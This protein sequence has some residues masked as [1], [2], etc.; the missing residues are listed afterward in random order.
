MLLKDDTVKRRASRSRLLP[1]WIASDNAASYT[2]FVV[3]LTEFFN[4]TTD[5]YLTS[6][7]LIYWPCKKYLIITQTSIWSKKHAYF[8]TNTIKRLL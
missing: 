3:I 7:D 4:Y 5:T 6:T 1:D 2:C 8:E